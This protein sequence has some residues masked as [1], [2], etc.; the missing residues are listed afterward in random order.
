MNTGSRRA[1]QRSARVQLRAKLWYRRVLDRDRAPVRVAHVHAAMGTGQ[2]CSSLLAGIIALS[3][4]SP[5]RGRLG[6]A[7][8]F[9]ATCGAAGTNKSASS[10]GFLLFSCSLLSFWRPCVHRDHRPMTL[11][12]LQL[13]FRRTAHRSRCASPFERRPSRTQCSFSFAP[14]AFGIRIQSYDRRYSSCSKREK[15]EHR[16]VW[17]VSFV[18]VS[19]IRAVVR[20]K[21]HPSPVHP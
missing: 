7:R 20:K 14:P 11:G 19:M 1:Q 5:A 17:S 21:L 18:S 10:S 4:E 16:V 8:L 9:R 12:I 15:I 3:T 13:E 2:R 6:T